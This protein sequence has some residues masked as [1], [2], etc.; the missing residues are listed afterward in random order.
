MPNPDLG[1][2]ERRWV[3]SCDLMDRWAGMILCVRMH[4]CMPCRDGGK[5]PQTK[6]LPCSYA[7]ES[8]SQARN[9][10]LFSAAEVISRGRKRDWRNGRARPQEPIELS[11]RHWG[12]TEEYKTREWQRET[13][14]LDRL[15]SVMHRLEGSGLE[16]G[17]HATRPLQWSGWEKMA[18]YGMNFSL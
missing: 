15:L 14:L 6:G 5:C 7:W 9:W 4:V 13:C 17:K 2:R 16:A 8:R 3:C 11:W 10:I 18:E 1:I 12:V